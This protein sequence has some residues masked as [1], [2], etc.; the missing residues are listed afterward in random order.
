MSIPV[1][2][3]GKSGT[4]PFPC[5]ENLPFFYSKKHMNT[6]FVTLGCSKSALV[7]LEIAE[8][9]GCPLFISPVGGSEEWAEL[10]RILKAHKRLPE[11][12]KYEF[13]EQAES[14]WILSK[15][16][17][18]QEALPW[19]TTGEIDLSGEKIKT[20][21]FL[22]W[23]ESICLSMKLADTRIDL[24][25][26]DLP[27]ELERGVL[28]SML[29]AGIRPSFVMVKWN[30]H[31]NTDVPTSLTAGHLQNCGYQLLGKYNNNF[32][33]Y[34][35][36]N[37]VYM[38]CNWDVTDVQNPI[39]KTIVDKIKYSKERIEGPN[40]RNTPPSLA[41]VRETNTILESE[42]TTSDT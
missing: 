37:D 15:N 14:K 12:S 33:Y 2:L 20:Q 22:S 27:A 25:K 4:D 30:K 18:F 38:M 10:T 28:M 13:T 7:D 31:P 17:R 39:I 1:F 16:L 36:D 32:L 26:V 19:W 23:T 11:N 42:T 29:D 8:P 21:T 24:I 40:V 5:I 3:L 35:T 34:Y 9:L 41:P 6:V